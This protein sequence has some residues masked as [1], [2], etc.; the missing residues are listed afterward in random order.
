MQPSR[1]RL[2]PDRIVGF[3]CLLVVPLAL[4]LA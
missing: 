4:W 2:D 1:R 3:V